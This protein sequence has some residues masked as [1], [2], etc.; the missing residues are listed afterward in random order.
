[1]D[2]SDRYLGVKIA[3]KIHGN[4]STCPLILFMLHYY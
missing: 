2:Y 1:M 3:I 4:F